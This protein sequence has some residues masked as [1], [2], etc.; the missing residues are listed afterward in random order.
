MTF[1]IERTYSDQVTSLR[2]SG[3]LKPECLKELKQ[4]IEKRGEGHRMI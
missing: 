4:Q 1:K 3:R 2:L